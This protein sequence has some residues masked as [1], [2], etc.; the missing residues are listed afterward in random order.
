M[1]NILVIDDEVDIVELVTYNLKRE[2]FAVETAH[3][4]EEGLKRISSK[5]YELIF[6]DLMLPGIQGIEFCKMVR[7]NPHTAHIPIVMLTAKNEES[8]KILGF[9]VG[10][11]DYITKSFSPRELVACAKALLRR[12]EEPV[13]AAPADLKDDN[14]LRIR[15]ITID[16]ERFIVTVGSRHIKLSVTEFN[17]LLLLAA[18]PLK[19]FNRQQLLDLVWGNDVYVEPRTVDVHIRRL[20]IKIEHNPNAPSYIKT[21]RGVGYYMDK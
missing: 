18:R 3:D 10:A 4:G 21:M 2:G 1:K 5:R 6:L 12:A 8:D 16:K 19:I 15:D 17:L 9:E 14:I 13:K 7:S 20:R 11:D